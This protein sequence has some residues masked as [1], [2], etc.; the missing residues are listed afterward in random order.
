MGKILRGA[1]PLP[2]LIVGNAFNKIHQAQK[3]LRIDY[4]N[5]REF[6]KRP[7]LPRHPERN[8]E[9]AAVRS[10]HGKGAIGVARSEYDL[11]L[12]FT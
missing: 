6:M 5:R 3:R 12:M 7:A 4:R 10:L 9:S 11:E 2:I 8:L 1:Q